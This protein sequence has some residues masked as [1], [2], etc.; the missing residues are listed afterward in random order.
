ML[1]TCLATARPASHPLILADLRVRL[2][3]SRLTEP[4]APVR[5]R[6]SSLP[7]SRRPECRSTRSG[8]SKHVLRRHRCNS[9][10]AAA[11]ISMTLSALILVIG[12]SLA[13]RIAANFAATRAQVVADSGAHAAAA[14]LAA[15]PMRDALS[16][17]TQISFGCSYSRD[18][19]TALAQ[20]DSGAGDAAPANQLCAQ[21]FAAA[22]DVVH[23]ND[24][25]ATVESFDVAT[26]AR[27]YV[28]SGG[29]TRLLAWV[30]VRVEGPLAHYSSICG[31]RTA[32]QTLCYAEASAS[33]RE[34]G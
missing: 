14:L 15:S 28:P 27:D 32:T 7:S 13:I 31:A 11:L 26:D 5:L 18:G 20:D 29:A 16:R 1:G 21:A 24:P 17:E 34:S 8:V 23:R 9:V 22:S 4:P 19:H 6:C 33:A 30:S 2:C 12:L 3:A 25:A 10:G